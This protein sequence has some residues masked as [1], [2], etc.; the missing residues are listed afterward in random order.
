MSETP[1]TDNNNY[2]KK[3]EQKQHTHRSCGKSKKKKPKHWLNTSGKLAQP[4]RQSL[5]LPSLSN[6]LSPFS[7]SAC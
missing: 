7:I 3:E 6:L 4:A 1:I 2:A 5:S